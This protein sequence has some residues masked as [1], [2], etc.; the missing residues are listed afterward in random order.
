MPAME[1]PVADVE[2]LG[3]G[4]VGLL[5]EVP[6]GADATDYEA[7]RARLAGSLPADLHEMFFVNTDVG[8]WDYGRRV[9]ER[10]IAAG[11]VT[12]ARVIRCRVPRTFI[13]CNRVEDAPAGGGLTASVP[14]Y[15]HDA[16]DHAFLLDLHRRYVA[17]VA[18][19][20]AALPERA[21]ALLPHT[22]G[23]RSLG[24]ETVGDDIVTRLRWAHEPGRVETWPLRPEVDLITR[25][26]DG[27][28]HAPAALV[29]AVAA[30]LG[31]RGLQVAD[32][33]TY[34]MHPATLAYRWA[35][36]RSSPT[37][38][39]EVR[40]DL[41]VREWIWNRESRIDPAAVDKIAAPLAE[42]IGAWIGTI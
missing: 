20:F 14:G 42:A 25:G 37:F 34:A 8:A 41:L 4:P 31:A 23:P 24:I 28:L 15:I 27:A 30:T 40:R 9:A 1:L 32:S 36:G 26:P 18:D 17:I 35:T 12:G 16:A 21:L 39:L 3:A 10:L 38:C 2:I 7:V 19:A 5:V 33:S 11:A 22:Y 29:E 13:D 6:H